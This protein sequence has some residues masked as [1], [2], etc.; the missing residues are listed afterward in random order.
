MTL[1]ITKIMSAEE[2]ER[3]TQKNKGRG[4]PL[5]IDLFHC[6]PEKFYHKVSCPTES[7]S[8]TANGTVG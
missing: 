6:C 7:L 3:Q 4:T 2:S 5:F 1:N 8:G